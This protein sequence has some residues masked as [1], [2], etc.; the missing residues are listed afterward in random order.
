MRSIA[1]VLLLALDIMVLGVL[2]YLLCAGEYERLT[3]S[4]L[5][6]ITGTLLMRARLPR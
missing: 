2:F 4:C 1:Y 5:F 6:V 3:A